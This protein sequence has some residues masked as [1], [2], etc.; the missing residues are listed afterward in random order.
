[1]KHA[2]PAALDALEPLLTGLRALPGLKEARRGVFHHRSKAFLHFHE[3]PSGLHADLRR[4]EAFERFRVETDA[5][6][7]R[8][9][10]LVVAAAAP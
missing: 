6:R 3:D 9:L 4:G 1:M 2:G 10:A 7:A 8:L 5:E